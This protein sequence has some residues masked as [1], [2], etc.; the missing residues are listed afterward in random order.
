M[1]RDAWKRL[2]VLIA[3]LAMLSTLHAAY[4]V[5]SILRE[6]RKDWIQD[7]DRA[8]RPLEVR[9]VRIENKLDRIADPKG[10]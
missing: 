10:D 3:A 2:G 9:T 8:I 7:I 5:P 4:V 6:A 1:N